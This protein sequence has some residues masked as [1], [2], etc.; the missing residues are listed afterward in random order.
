[1]DLKHKELT[2]GILKTFYE[3]YNELGY[4]FLEKVYQN[5]MYIELK[6][7]GYK[8][9]AQSKIKVYYKETEVGEYYA[10]LM[11]ENLVILEL[12]A[13]DY[14]VKDF[15]NQI[16]NYLRSTDC[17]VG[18]LLNFGKKPEFRRKIFENNRK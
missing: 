13:V 4:G 2:D 8:V 18:L 15:E 9:E 5:S 6:N 11:V 17:E 14:I 16:L 7:K 3:V 12:K 1:M 10:D